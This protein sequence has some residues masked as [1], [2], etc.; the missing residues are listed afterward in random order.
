MTE[1]DTYKCK[2]CG[3]EWGFI[4]EDYEKREDYPDTCPL[5]DMPIMD[6]IRDIT[7]EE[8]FVAAIKHLWVRITKKQ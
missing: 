5:C 4:P 7:R 3:I 1:E 8:G 2:V 6:M